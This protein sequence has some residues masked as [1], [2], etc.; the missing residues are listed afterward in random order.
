M[1][2]FVKIHLKAGETKTVDFELSA[3]DLAFYNIKNERVIESGA[4]DL[5][6]GGSSDDNLRSEFEL[7]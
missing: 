7:K 5:W 6:V 3:E 1:A 2:R 4:Y